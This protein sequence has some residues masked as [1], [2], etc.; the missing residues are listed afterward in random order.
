MIK[1]R[2][3][4]ALAAVAVVGTLGAIALGASRSAPLGLEGVVFVQ[5]E[6][7]P[8]WL[9]RLGLVDEALERSEMSRAIYEWREA[10]GAATRTKDSQALIAVA[11]RAVRI[12]ELT[13]DS[14]YFLHEARY[15]YQHA[16]SRARA[17][18]SPEALNG[19][20]QAL[21]KLGDT[22]RARQMRRIAEQLS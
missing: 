1:T 7:T 21:D 19:I 8:A 9:N 11:Q 16:A 2:W 10:Y 20:A 12:A 5:P 13:V 3:S 4:Q 6:P 17:E 22:E 14:G 18:R 15:I